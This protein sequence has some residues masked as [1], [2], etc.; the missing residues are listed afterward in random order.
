MPIARPTRPRVADGLR[1]TQVIK[2]GLAPVLL[3]GARAV[4][5][6]GTWQDALNRLGS[7]QPGELTRAVGPGL[8]DV[9]ADVDRQQLLRFRSS[10]RRFTDR[11]GALRPLDPFERTRATLRAVTYAERLPTVYQGNLQNRLAKLAGKGV[12]FTPQRLRRAVAQSQGVARNR[13]RL[14]GFDQVETFNGELAVRRQREVGV[15]RFQIVTAG[16]DR[17]RPEHAAEDGNVYSW[18]GVYP[19]VPGAPVA[20]RC[21]AA[22]VFD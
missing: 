17:V 11:A 5:G 6:A 1:A 3:D 15:D 14:V 12:E 19:Y 18:S 2:R 22:P 7:W 8:R 21:G 4:A 9:L 13:A 16:D 20:C 10:V